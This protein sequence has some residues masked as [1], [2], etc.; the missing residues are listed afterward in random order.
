LKITDYLAVY[1]AILSSLVFVWNVT[2]SRPRLKVDLAFALEDVHGELKPGIYVVIRNMSSQDVHLAN[3]S[4]LYPYQQAGIKSKIAHIWRYK[5]VP[6]NLGWVHSSLSNYSLDSGCPM[7][8]EA[9]KS[10]KIFIA[11]T[12]LEGVWTE[13]LHESVRACVQ[14]QLWNNIYSKSFKFS[15]PKLL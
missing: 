15:T 7:C 13:A 6:S 1:A 2:Q 8:L 3:V 12:M 14:D 11:K 5:R 10:H 9:R 4:I